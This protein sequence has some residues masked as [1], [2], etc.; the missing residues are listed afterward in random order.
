MGRLRAQYYL[1]AL[2][3]V[4]FDIEVMFLFPFALAYEKVGLFAVIEAILF[5]VIL[6][7]G[8]LYAWKKKALEW[9]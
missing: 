4:V 1:F 2:I 5:V 7:V 6:A 3:F 8:L 9:Q